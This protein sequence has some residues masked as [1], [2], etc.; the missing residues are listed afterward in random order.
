MQPGIEEG[1]LGALLTL[2]GPLPCHEVT[3]RCLTCPLVPP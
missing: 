1:G 3:G 2:Q